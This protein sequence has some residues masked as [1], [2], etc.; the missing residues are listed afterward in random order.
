MHWP[1]SLHAP[2]SV[3]SS[4][5]WCVVGC[6]VSAA[7]SDV[8]LRMGWCGHVGRGDGALVDDGADV[9]ADVGARVP[10]MSSRSSSSSPLVVLRA[11]VVAFLPNGDVGVSPRTLF[12]GS[13]R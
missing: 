9:G 1:D 13:T 10:A 6:G 8:G 7:R 12:H 5:S 2:I 3:I 4:H 11:P